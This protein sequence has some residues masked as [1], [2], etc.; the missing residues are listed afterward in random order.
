MRV[1]KSAPPNLRNLGL[2]KSTENIQISN[3]DNSWFY[4]TF[5]F[6]VLLTLF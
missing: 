1:A 3:D 5:I 2:E 4:V 6:L